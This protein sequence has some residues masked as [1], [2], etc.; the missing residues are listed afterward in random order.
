MTLLGAAST[1][2]L[3]TSARV[4]RA[5]A[6]QSFDFS[7]DPGTGAVRVSGTVD[8]SRLA[9]R[10]ST[11]AGERTEELELDAAPTLALNL[12]RRLADGHLRPGARYTWSVFDPATLRNA[13]M[14][15]EVGEREVVRAGDVRIP[16]FRVS[17]ESAG[18]TVT[19]WITDTGEIVREDS[20]LGLMTVRESADTA[21]RM[22]VSGRTR[23][24][25]LASAAVVPTMHGQIDDSRDVERMRLQITGVDLSLADMQGAGQTATGN[26]V[27]LRNPTTIQPEAAD[28]DVGRYLLPEPFIESDAPEILAET[29]KALRGLRDP[30]ARAEQLV[31]YVN[32]LLEKKPT[33]SLPSAREVL[34][35][36]IGD[37]NEHTALY[38]AMA[39]AAGIPARIAVGLAFVNDAFYY[40]AWPEVYL[41]ADAAHGNWL[42]VDPTFNQFPAD[43]TH[44]RLV[45]G[46]LDRQAAILPLI[47]RIR[48]T[49]L[50]LDVREGTTRVTVGASR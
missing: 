41:A 34:R 42:P 38:V 9:L 19:S 37:C 18:L 26:V 28:P 43:G 50:D 17:M 46:G 16:A 40:H 10:I 1:A 49:V 35:T 24:D 3:H 30:R 48:I 6:L 44:V 7:M 31:R 45:R 47:G 33:I 20:P 29:E 14:V 23:Q 27:E 22:A 13:P 8:G 36:R 39:R 2:K 12:G 4:D 11:V 5:F 25:M 21:T 32:G 15:I